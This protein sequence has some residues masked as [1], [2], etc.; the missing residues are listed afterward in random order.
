MTRVTKE[1]GCLVVV[2]GSHLGELMPH[3]NPEWEHL[4]GGYFGVKD[5]G[6]QLDRRVHLEMEPGDTVFFHP[7]ILHGSGRNRTDGFRRAISA[8]YAATEC[9]W[10]WEIEDS[11]SRMYRI[12]TGEGAGQ[13]WNGMRKVPTGGVDPIDF[14]PA[15]SPLDDSVRTRRDRARAAAAEADK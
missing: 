10:I 13:Q 14:V 15:D 8:H 5:I 12:V 11:A 9:E 7:I 1:N 3:D 2:P 6:D 4:N